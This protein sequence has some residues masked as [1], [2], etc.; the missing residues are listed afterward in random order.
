M[1]TLYFTAII[2]L[3]SA[4]TSDKECVNVKLKNLTGLDGCGWVLVLNDGSKLEPI[5]LSEF[6]S[7]PTENQK[8]CITYTELQSGS[9][10]M[11]GKVVEINTWEE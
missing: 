9:F 6:E 4:C 10:C 1:K 3:L 5:N 8:A 7:S 11:V 2:L